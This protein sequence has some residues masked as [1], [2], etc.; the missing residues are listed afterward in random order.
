MRSARAAA[1][2]PPSSKTRAKTSISPERF[3]SNRATVTSDRDG[4]RHSLPPR[5]LLVRRR[6]HSRQTA[7]DAVLRRWSPDLHGEMQRKRRT[8]IRGIHDRLSFAFRPVIDLSLRTIRENQS[9]TMSVQNRQ[10]IL[11]GGLLLAR[12]TDRLHESPFSQ[13]SLCVPPPP[14]STASRAGLSCRKREFA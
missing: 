6:E 2:N 4:E 1:E 14:L 5:R 12:L 8:R 13:P 7:R 11:H 3:T 9:V 10:W